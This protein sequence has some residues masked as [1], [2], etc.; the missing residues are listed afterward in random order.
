MK[1]RRAKAFLQAATGKTA[2]LAAALA[3]AACAGEPV[4]DGSGRPI[5]FPQESEAIDLAETDLT[6]PLDS[7]FEISVVRERVSEGQVFE[8]VYKFHHLKGFVRTSR[9]IFGHYSRNTSSDLRT[10]RA[11]RDYVGD[12]SIPPA[13]ELEPGQVRRFD[14]GDPHTLGYYAFA[15]AEP[16]HPRCFVARVGY[17]LVDYASVKREPDSVDTIVEVFLCGKLPSE[18][19][20]L[21]FLAKVKTVDDREAYRRELSRRTV[22]TI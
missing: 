17:L 22:G 18:E 2:A 21:D 12:L 10:A 1:R 5:N 4:D 20:L 19:V 6:L 3:L 8:N 7:P 13:D 11:F 15:S 14:N 16:Y 9:I